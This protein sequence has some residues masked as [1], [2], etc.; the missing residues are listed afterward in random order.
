MTGRKPMPS[1]LRV[2]KGNPGK[3]PIN[4]DEP[5]PDGELGEPLKHLTQP[6]RIVWKELA[7]LCYWATE[8]DRPA[9]ELLVVNFAKTRKL[10]K[11]LDKEKSV[12]RGTRGLVRNPKAY[13]LR[14]AEDRAVRLFSAFG[15]DP[16]SRTRIRVPPKNPPVDPLAQFD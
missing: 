8:S 15:L 3:R 10:R 16:S 13:E 6:E 9:F 11:E 12:V 1:R 2:L 7:Q 4:R 5:Q 14:E